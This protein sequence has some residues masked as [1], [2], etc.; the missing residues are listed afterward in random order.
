MKHFSFRYRDDGQVLLD[1]SE[2]RW[3]WDALVHAADGVCALSR[4]R[5]CGSLVAWAYGVNE[6]HIRY[7]LSIPVDREQWV[8][9]ATM[10]GDDDPSWPWWE[11]EPLADRGEL[12]DGENEA[13]TDD[14]RRGEDG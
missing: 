1:I 2:C 10:M 9:W 14:L 7:Q 6:R 5:L 12:H 11:D 8:A 3:W 4:H 13:L